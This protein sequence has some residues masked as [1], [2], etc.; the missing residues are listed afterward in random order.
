[1][2]TR[3]VNRPPVKVMPEVDERLDEE[4]EAEAVENYQPNGGDDLVPPDI[5]DRPADGELG[6]GD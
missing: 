3:H 2:A 6:A 5:I 4:R 1:M